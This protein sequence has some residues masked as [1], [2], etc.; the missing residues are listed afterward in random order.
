MHIIALLSLW[1]AKIYAAEQSLEHL[2]PGSGPIT[3]CEHGLG[4]DFICF[5]EDLIHSIYK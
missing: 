4:Q 5:C 3:K 1:W 2:V